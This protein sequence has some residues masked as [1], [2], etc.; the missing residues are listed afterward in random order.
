VRLTRTAYWSLGLVAVVAAT[1]W[2]GALVSTGRWEHLDDWND[3]S[4]PVVALF[5]N[6]AVLAVVVGFCVSVWLL[7]MTLESTR[8]IDD[9][10][11]QLARRLNQLERDD[12]CRTRWLESLE[13]RERSGAQR[14]G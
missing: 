14:T 9:E 10:R 8:D 11:Q 12:A 2:L 7:Y 4:I 5:Q 3:S 13:R 6:P 1:A